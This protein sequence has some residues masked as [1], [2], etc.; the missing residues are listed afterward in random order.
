MCDRAPTWLQYARFPEG[1][2]PP[3]EPCALRLLQEGPWYGFAPTGYKLM[4]RVSH[5]ERGSALDQLNKYNREPFNG[6]E[7]QQERRTGRGQTPLSL[8]TRFR[9]QPL[10][11][12]GATL[13]ALGIDRSARP[14]KGAGVPSMQ[15][16]V[17]ASSP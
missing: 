2:H 17:R 12:S 15:N 3:L 11:P 1:S 14:S 10:A 5:S 6:E 7:D 8:G 13:R 4:R 16:C 9:R